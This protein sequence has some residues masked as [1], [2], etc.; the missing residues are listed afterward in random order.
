[1]A[2]AL[3]CRPKRIIGVRGTQGHHGHISYKVQTPQR[4]L[5]VYVYPEYL[6]RNDMCPEIPGN[7]HIRAR[8]QHDVVKDEGL[9]P[10]TNEK[11][12]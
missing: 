11:F 9:G 2:E 7:E 10:K 5:P 6:Q 8:S 12:G 4:S 1:M 3:H